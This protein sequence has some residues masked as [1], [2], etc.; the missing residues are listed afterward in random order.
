MGSASGLC[1]AYAGVP[2][3]GHWNPVLPL[4]RELVARGAR[5]EYWSCESVREAA[6]KA[7]ARFYAYHDARVP[8]DAASLSCFGAVFSTLMR[9]CEANFAPFLDALRSSRPDV[10]LHDQFCPWAKW[11]GGLLALPAASCFTTFVF[12]KGAGGGGFLS[13]LDGVEDA[14]RTRAA[15]SERWGIPKWGIIDALSNKEEANLVFRMRELQRPEPA[16][17]LYPG[18]CLPERV[19][20]SPSA[21]RGAPSG[22]SL[23][24]VSMGTVYPAKEGV[25]ERA[26]RSF[27]A[28]G[29]RVLVAAG[30]AYERLRGLADGEA[31]RVEPWIDQL[32]ELES[33]S[34]FLGHGA[35]NGLQEA[36][37][38][39]V[40]SF[41]VPH[42][43]EQAAVAAIAEELGVARV[44][45]LDFDLG[46][47][48]RAAAEDPRLVD[49]L[50]SA[51][52]GLRMA[53]GAAMAADA[54]TAL[55]E[56]GGGR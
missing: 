14:N 29:F 39:K 35:V 13:G 11:A 25:V 18:P 21:S 3:F 28:A 1:V 5:V 50:E 32:S 46:R 7:G 54:V 27:R 56:R 8:F 37:F 24:L 45:D 2:L 16:D 40:P 20:A 9:F 43:R 22:A 52:R 55:A 47:E 38:R 23:A 15:L 34:V 19:E 12:E 42:T 51:G 44:W 10:L 36:L 17:C 31:V 26:V 4:V 41:H 30:S 48:A 53:G 33:A 49:R 6:E